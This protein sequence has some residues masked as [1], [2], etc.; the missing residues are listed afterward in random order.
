MAFL[1]T[2]EGEPC[3]DRSN[4]GR[5][6]RL[7]TGE[8]SEQPLN[9]NIRPPSRLLD[10]K[11]NSPCTPPTSSSST[12]PT[13]IGGIRRGRA[14]ASTRP[15]L[16]RNSNKPA[17]GM[18]REDEQDAGVFSPGTACAIPE[19]RRGGR[20]PSSRRQVVAGSASLRIPM[21]VGRHRHPTGKDVVSSIEDEGRRVFDSLLKLERKDGG[22][23]SAPIV[24][25]NRPEHRGPVPAPSWSRT[26]TPIDSTPVRILQPSARPKLLESE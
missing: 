2:Q 13:C 14:S 6:T 10:L 11:R 26:N 23:T 9:G 17:R 4:T 8:D 22:A 3:C 20:V 19:R 7:L 1:A 21:G 18:E 25:S 15:G 5:V 24:R 12:M 16:Y